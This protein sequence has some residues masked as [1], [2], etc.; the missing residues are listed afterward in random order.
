MAQQ[1]RLEPT[2]AT[3]FQASE[4]FAIGG[5]YDEELKGMR[6]LDRLCLASLI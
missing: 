6:E 4:L 5:S 2:I 1:L 3:D